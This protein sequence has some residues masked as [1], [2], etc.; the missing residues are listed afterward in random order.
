MVTVVTFAIVVTLLLVDGQD[1]CDGVDG[2]D[3]DDEIII[4]MLLTT[5]AF[6]K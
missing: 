1:G 5:G 4:S 6:F 3:D 2:C